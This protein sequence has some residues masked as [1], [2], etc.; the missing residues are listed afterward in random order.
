MGLHK[1]MKVKDT[2]DELTLAKWTS[3]PRLRKG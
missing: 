3:K 1:V 2:K